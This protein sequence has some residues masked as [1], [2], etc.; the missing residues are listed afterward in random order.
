MISCNLARATRMILITGGLGFIGSHTARAV[1]DLGEVVL[2]T[3]HRAGQ[4]PDFLTGELGRRVMVEQVDVADRA[5]FL[6]IGRHHPITGIIHLASP[7]T[8]DA[9]ENVQANT[10]GL[11]NALRA[12]QDWG[13]ARIGIASTVGVY[14]GVPAVPFREDVPLPMSPAL[15]IPVFKKAAE[16]FASLI[17][18]SDGL[19]VV[20]LRI[21]TIWGPLIRNLEPVVPRL[22]HAAVNHQ[23]PAPPEPYADDG[24]DLCYVKDCARHRAPRARRPPQP[25]HLQHRSGTSH[26][27]HRDRRGH[28]I[29]PPARASSTPART[30]PPRPGPRHLP[31]HHPNQP[32]H[33]LP[34]RIRYLPRHHRVSQLAAGRTPVLAH[35]P[36]KSLITLRRAARTA[37]LCTAVA[38]S[39]ARPSR[40]ITLT[41]R[42]NA[43]GIRT[44]AAGLS[45]P[46][47]ALAIAVTRRICPT[48]QRKWRTVT[49]YAVTSL[50]AS[51][52]S[53]AR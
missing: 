28:P 41:G 3:Q 12:A 26:R 33:R 13:V 7:R 51:Q 48:D 21:S 31:R 22:V 11:L 27:E 37:P 23:P 46:H 49:V 39:A 17:A 19:D 53:P 44:I 38:G 43:T 47:A 5:A 9:I 50:T 14:V 15:P 36:A 52:A 2:L 4:I 18:D 16:L 20:N 42:T 40:T 29:R 24:A 34:A 6:K 25:P 45:F 1:L 10:Q 30:R 8:P 32:R 35:D